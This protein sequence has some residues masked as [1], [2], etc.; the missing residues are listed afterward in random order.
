MQQTH[1]TD[2]ANRYSAGHFN[3]GVIMDKEQK[4]YELEDVPV[5][6]YEEMEVNAPVVPPKP[7]PKKPPEKPAVS[8]KPNPARYVHNNDNQNVC[9]A[10]TMP[11]MHSQFH[12]RVQQQP[13][14]RSNSPEIIYNVAD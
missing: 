1:S 13:Q 8:H 5:D 3:K 2:A 10:S 9:K 7:Q 11:Q 6:S 12:G 14:M 4:D